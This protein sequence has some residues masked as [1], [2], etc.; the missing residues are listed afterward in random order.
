MIGWYCR[1]SKLKIIGLG[2][3]TPER[4][5]TNDEIQE[6]VNTS[7]E[8]IK[9]RLGIDERRISNNDERT[10]DL[11][12]KA[13]V[14]ALE[15]C[16]MSIDEIDLIIVATSTPDRKSPS[17]ACILQEKFTCK[18]IP[19]FDVNAVCSGFI[20]GLDIC[21]S[22]LMSGK[23]KKILLVGAEQY[24]TITDWDRR[25]CV[26]FGDGA[27]AVILE[28]D[29]NSYFRSLIKA[30]GKGK[31]N[32]TVPRGSQYF[33]MNGKEVF[34]Q[35]TMVLPDSIIELLESNNLNTD[36]VDLCVP[37]Q[38]SIKILELTA[39]KIGLPF[40]KVART[41]NKYANTAGASIPI[42]LCDSYENGRLKKGDLVLF[43]A[44]GSGW[45]WGSAIMR[46]SI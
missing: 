8:W 41:M 30:D 33:E 7:S 18:N 39:K 34:K 23:Y 28:K 15:S 9:E 16:N 42:T 38:P 44:V 13:S 31:E 27:G 2:K 1:R 25:D 17:T 4:V 24:S 40:H 32:F 45:T 11:A 10:S 14:K 6:T 22:L 5:L 12:F 35:A 36:D 21:S 3:Y 29:N 26:F 20:Y 43:T 19:A 37:H 46:W